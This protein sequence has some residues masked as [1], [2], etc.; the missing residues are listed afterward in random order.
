MN[1]TKCLQNCWQRG[2]IEASTLANWLR[3]E[4]FLAMR[5]VKPYQQFCIH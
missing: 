3:G 2:Y 1:P 4:D 5:E